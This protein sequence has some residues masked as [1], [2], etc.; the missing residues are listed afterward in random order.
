[1]S[2]SRSELL[3]LCNKIKADLDPKAVSSLGEALE[4]RLAKE[5][6]QRAFAED[7]ASKSQSMLNMIRAMMAHD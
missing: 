2:Q 7:K 5:K 4:V 6:I 1:M 3:S